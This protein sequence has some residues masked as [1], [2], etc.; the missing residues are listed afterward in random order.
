MDN[1][2]GLI[3]SIG[4]E[5]STA[6]KMYRYVLFAFSFFYWFQIRSHR[7]ARLTRNEPIYN[8]MLTVILVW[9]LFYFL[10]YAGFNSNELLGLADLFAK[11]NGMII[12]I[13]ALFITA[14][15][16]SVGF[17]NRFV[18]RFTVVL[19][20]VG[21][22]SLITA[23]TS[24][25]LV[26]FDEF[27]RHFTSVKRIVFVGGKIIY[28]ILPLGVAHIALNIERDYKIY[29]AF[30]LIFT[31]I[32]VAILRRWMFALVEYFVIIFLAKNYIQSL[33]L[34][35]INRRVTQTVAVVVLSFFVFVG[36]IRKE[37][38]A[39][40]NDSF[41]NLISLAQG[42]SVEGTADDTRLSLTKQ[43]SM[44]NAFE[45]NFYFGTGY[46]ER[47]FNNKN[48]NDNWEGADYIFL[49]VLGQFGIFGIMIFLFYYVLIF[50]TII[51]GYRLMRR[52]W[53]W[54]RKNNQDTYYYVMIF[55]ATS[56]EFIRNI[57]EYP[58]WFVPISAS[59]FGYL[60]FIYGG[61]LIGTYT[62]LK[63]LLPQKNANILA[64]KFI[65]C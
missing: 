35:A 50:K 18:N 57:F 31:M 54:I 52:N 61:M 36:I 40:L 13:S 45:E 46:D 11:H 58:N 41:Q 26:Q 63:L 59:S 25:N 47:W 60:Y 16:A 5:S 49:G 28:F 32:V 27:T 20:I 10:V 53:H 37:Y 51:N 2:G 1:P 42:E 30:V 4:I 33:P 3:F 17:L 14:Q 39:V 19:V 12:G 22:L 9:S 24:L 64:N 43:E 44:L 29:T 23:F 38:F 56:A 62:G 6:V 34:L 7:N 15:V 21:V 55:I 65:E 48:V 8:Q